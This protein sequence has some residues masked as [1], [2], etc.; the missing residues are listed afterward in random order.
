M[1]QAGVG[2]GAAGRRDRRR[3]RRA[4]LGALVACAAFAADLPVASAEGKRGRIDTEL[5]FDFIRAEAVNSRARDGRPTRTGAQDLGMRLRVDTRHERWSARID[6]RGREAIA[7]DVRNSS[8]R[9]LYAAHLDYQVVPDRLALGVGRFLAPSAVLLPVDAVRARW[10]VGDL[11][12]SAFGG[13]RAILTSRR[14][15]DLANFLPAGGLTLGWRNRWARAR[16]LVSYSADQAILV[17]AR[18]ER[19]KT[20]HAWNGRLDVWLRPIPTLSLL[21]RLAVAERARYTIGPSFD[22][23]DLELGSLDLSSGGARIDWRPREHLR[24]RYGVH[25]QRAGVFRVGFVRDAASANVS[26]DPPDEPRFTDHRIGIAW[27]AFDRGWLRSDIRVRL[28]PDREEQRFGIGLDLDELGFGGLELRSRYYYD[29]IDP[30]SRD[31]NR[32]ASDR[33]FFSGS[34][35]YRGRALDLEVGASR[36]ER[37]ASPYSGRRA[38]PREPDSPEDLSLFTLESETIGFLRLF[39]LH[40]VHFSGVDVEIDLDDPREIRF[41]MQFGARWRQRW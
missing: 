8:L 7:G 19:T 35:A 3:R 28:R 29:R 36:L 6:Y 4:G 18:R 27:R 17:S 33:Q 23:V 38:D 20:F 10:Q 41:F 15:V 34:I 25:T 26:R 31:G 24:L 1:A 39:Y 21:G 37:N 12:L 13:R 30:G 9:L 11:E 5:V 40:G 2:V 16:A 32:F 14:N 22:R